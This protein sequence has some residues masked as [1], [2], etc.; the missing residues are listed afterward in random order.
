MHGGDHVAVVLDFHLVGERQQL[1]L[2]RRHFLSGPVLELK[3]TANGEDLGVD[4]ENPVTVL[5]GNPEVFFDGEQPL[6]YQIAHTRKL[7][8]SA[9]ILLH[10]AK[11]VIYPHSGR[12]RSA[13]WRRRP[14]AARPSRPGQPVNRAAPAPSRWPGMPP[15]AARWGK[16]S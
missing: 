9:A 13:R 14:G 10:R 11:A 12:M 3:G 8:Q 1:V 16:R 5:V 2:D 7:P 15:W 4:E 6:P